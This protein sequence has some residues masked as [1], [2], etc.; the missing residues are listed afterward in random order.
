MAELAI[1][2]SLIALGCAYFAYTKSGGSIEDLR[3]KVEDLGLTTESLRNKT[4]DI[5]ANLEKKVRYEDKK[6]DNQA[7]DKDDSR[8]DIH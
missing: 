4:A 8:Q 2:I 5:L 3:R 1:I 7:E 6:C